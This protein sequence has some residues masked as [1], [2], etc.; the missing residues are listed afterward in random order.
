MAISLAGRPD[1]CQVAGRSVHCALHGHVFQGYFSSPAN[2][3]FIAIERGLARLNDIIIT[4]SP[5]IRQELVER[6]GIAPAD[7]IRVVPPGLDFGWVED[8][9][10]RRGWLRALLGVNQSTP[11]FGMVGRLT[12]I[13]NVP[14]VLQAFARF[15]QTK[16][17]E[18][19]LVIIGDGEMRSELESLARVLGIARRVTF[20]GWML[21]RADIFSDLDVTCLTSFNEGLPISLI[22]SLAAAVP[23]IATDVGGVSDVVE[24]ATDGELVNSGECERFAAALVKVAQRRRMVSCERS[25]AVRE[26]YS[27]ARMAANIERIYKEL[28]ERRTFMPGATTKLQP[29]V[30]S[31]SVAAPDAAEL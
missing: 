23:V 9:K 5:R 16:A 13:K 25:A 11:I 17:V 26:R 29:S 30:G 10:R 1:W 18:A 14:M 2:S 22:E 28:L 15:L 4:V 27:T 19:R 8:L 31:I 20:C 21:E 24:P 7:K 3:A 12:K 6:Y